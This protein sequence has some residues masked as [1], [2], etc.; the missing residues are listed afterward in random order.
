M[1]L[2]FDNHFLEHGNV[3]SV[4][5]YLYNW[6][7]PN[8]TD[9]LTMFCFK[10]WYLIHLP[11]RPENGESWPP[12]RELS[13]SLKDVG[14]GGHIKAGLS[15]GTSG[16]GASPVRTCKTVFMEGLF[17]WVWMAAGQPQNKNTLHLFLYE[18]SIQSGVCTFEDCSPPVK[19][20]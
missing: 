4:Y 14:M 15:A 17:F 2:F 12:T 16:G 13:H 10:P 7:K 5:T 3:I 1:L 20:P 18:Y 8:H 6:L 19:F 9:G 11:E